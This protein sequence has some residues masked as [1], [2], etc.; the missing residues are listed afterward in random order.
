MKFFSETKVILALG[1]TNSSPKYKIPME[2]PFFPKQS[3]TRS[4]PDVTSGGGYVQ[5]RWVCL[6]HI[7]RGCGYVGGEGGYP[8]HMTYPT[9]HVM[10]PSHPLVDRMTDR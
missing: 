1:H 5:E 8:Y 9:M 3:Q 7:Q 4:P 6:R 10:L 2:S